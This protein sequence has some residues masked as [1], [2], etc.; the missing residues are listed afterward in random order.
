MKQ[1]KNDRLCL[2]F[3]PQSAYIGARFDWCGIIEQVVLD[4]QYE[5][6]IR[7]LQD[8]QG[9][10]QGGIGLCNEFGLDGPLGQ[11]EELPYC[12][13]IG[14]GEVVQNPNPTPGNDYILRDGKTPDIQAVYT[15]DTA[16]FTLTQTS[17]N[18]Y[19]YHYVKKVS[20]D[21]NRV[22][23]E[24][25]VKNIGQ[26]RIDTK[27][28]YH[29]FVHLNHLPVDAH[30]HLKADQMPETWVERDVGQLSIN[31]ADFGFPGDVDQ[32]F[33]CRSDEPKSAH[34]W[35]LSHDE[36]GL[37]ITEH[38]QNPAVRFAI[39]G[40]PHVFSCELFT[41]VSLAVGETYQNKRVMTFDKQ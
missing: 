33:Y 36:A 41:Q 25:T 38:C 29:N 13:K 15:A 24:T 26:K 28:Y 16:I 14:V 19:G 3:A 5:F 7:H 39:W 31:Q 27:E 1:L 17:D 12:M 8:E 10:T 18:G 32:V 2:S 20:L 37:S 40:L 35:T 21:G 4:D 22:V 9:S 11:D 23:F 34:T 6:C 30:Y